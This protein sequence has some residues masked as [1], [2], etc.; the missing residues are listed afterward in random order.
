M[1][2]QLA[3]CAG[4]P[5]PKAAPSSAVA[6]SQVFKNDIYSISSTSVPAN[7]S[8]RTFEQRLLRS[9]AASFCYSQTVERI[10]KST[11]PAGV[12]VH[13]VTSVILPPSSA[14]PPNAVI[15]FRTNIEE[16]VK[17]QIVATFIDSVTM[18]SPTVTAEVQAIS[19]PLPFPDAVAES[20]I[21][22]VAKRVMAN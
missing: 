15:N 10:V 20:A 9:P 18:E 22:A 3:K 16:N 21:S 5:V 4:L 2:V 13:L 7:P 19:G 11:L 17:G 14:Q 1:V 6:E 8:V 12:T